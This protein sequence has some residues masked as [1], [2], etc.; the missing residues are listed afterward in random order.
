MP[1]KTYMSMRKRTMSD[2]QSLETRATI[3][4]VENKSFMMIHGMWFYHYLKLYIERGHMQDR[5]INKYQSSSFMTL[6]NVWVVSLWEIYTHEKNIESVTYLLV[7]REIPHYTMR[8]MRNYKK[9]WYSCGRNSCLYIR[10]FGWN[11]IFY[12]LLWEKW[13]YHMY[14]WDEL[15]KSPNGGAH[16][17]SHLL[18]THWIILVTPFAIGSRF[19]EN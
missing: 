13:F 17:C 19:L 11:P 14:M 10:I 5:D 3:W 7:L 6:A 18:F 1:L 12:L 16:D 2:S 4:L 8:K 15:G 9:N